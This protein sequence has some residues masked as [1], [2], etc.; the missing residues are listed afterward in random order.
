MRTFPKLVLSSIALAAAASAGAAETIIKDPVTVNLS[1][2]TYGSGNSVNVGSPVYNGQ[3]G[4]FSGVLSNAG[5]YDNASFATYCVELGQTFNWNVTYN[6]YRIVKGDT[7]S[8][9]AGNPTTAGQIGQLMTYVDTFGSLTSVQSTGVQLAIWELIYETGN[10][11]SLDTGTFTNTPSSSNG[12][13]N[14]LLAGFSSTTSLYNVDV[15]KNDN[16]QDFLVLTAVPEPQAY[17]LALAGL[18]LVGV[19]GRKMRGEKK[20]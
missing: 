17:A 5:A 20:A 2:W 10:S 9:W 14:T 4:G 16:H 6:D 8:L 7:Y 15:L 19:F 13:A 18:A 12:F 1:S 3:G 11:Y